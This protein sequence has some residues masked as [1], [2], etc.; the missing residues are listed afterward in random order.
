MPRPASH[1]Y[2]IRRRL[3]LRQIY[4]ASS[5]ICAGALMPRRIVLLSD[6][7]GNSSASF[8]RTNVWR[9]FCALDLTSSNQ[10][11]CYDDG[12]GTSSFKPLAY[13]GGAFGIGL[14]RN[15]IS[16]YKFACRN[17]QPWRIHD[18]GCHRS[19]HRSGAHSSGQYFRIRARQAGPAGL[20]QLSSGAFPHELGSD[21][22]TDQEVVRAEHRTSD[23]AAGRS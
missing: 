3:P 11:A 15:V 14:R 17:F 23:G 18:Q 21:R 16:L 10:V 8:W 20:P 4:S 5:L 13:L 12:V 1:T 6:G 7:T 2:F 22:Q 19:D 9:M